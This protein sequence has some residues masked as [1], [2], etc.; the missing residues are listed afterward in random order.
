MLAIYD[1]FRAS[2]L[3]GSSGGLI[4]TA[5]TSPYLFLP[6]RNCTYNHGA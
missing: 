6:L 1:S 2:S 3:I 5:H 4:I